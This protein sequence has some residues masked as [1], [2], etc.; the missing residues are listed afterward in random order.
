MSQHQFIIYRPFPHIHIQTRGKMKVT[1]ETTNHHSIHS[2]NDL[3]I[4]IVLPLAIS[5]TQLQR[6]PF[7]LCSSQ[8]IP[9]Q[10]GRVSSASSILG[11]DLCPT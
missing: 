6:L 7:V 10:V 8:G 11:L 9:E 2:Y 4:F 5:F 1:E 3:L